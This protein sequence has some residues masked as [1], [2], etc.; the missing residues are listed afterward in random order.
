VK[1]D[2]GDCFD[3]PHRRCPPGSTLDVVAE[4]LNWRFPFRGSPRILSVS[5]LT[6]LASRELPVAIADIHVSFESQAS[7]WPVRL[8]IAIDVHR[9]S[10]TTPC[11]V[12]C[13]S[14]HLFTDVRDHRHPAGGIERIT[15]IVHLSTTH[16]CRIGRKSIEVRLAT[17]HRRR[18]PPA[19]G[20]R[21]GRT[22]ATA[23]CGSRRGAEVEEPGWVSTTMRPGSDGDSQKLPE[24]HVGWK[25]QNLHIGVE[26]NSRGVCASTDR[27]AQGDATPDTRRRK[28]VA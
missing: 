9:R 25:L 17:E 23:W 7:R 27:P 10:S 21:F 22:P 3:P 5:M 6:S 26:W 24:I 11:I 8:K 16:D 19:H 20:L 13:S 12:D 15:D 2:W 1:P 4:D 14:E 28:L 18:V